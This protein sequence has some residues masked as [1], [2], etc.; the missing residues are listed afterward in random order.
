[1]LLFRR[2]IQRR[3][4]LVRSAGGHERGRHPV[5]V[6]LV[7]G[8]QQELR[9]G[10]PHKRPKQGSEKRKRLGRSNLYGFQIKK[11]KVSRGNV[12]ISTHFIVRPSVR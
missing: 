2:S 6:R 11:G 4:S 10:F 7:Q 8:L 12:M 5:G 9:G 3:D 1:M